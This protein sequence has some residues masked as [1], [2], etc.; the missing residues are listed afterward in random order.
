MAGGCFHC[1]F[2]TRHVHAHHASNSFKRTSDHGCTGVSTGCTCASRLK[3]VQ[4]ALSRI[5]HSE[6]QTRVDRHYGF[7]F[8][9]T[10][11][12]NSHTNFFWRVEFVQ[13]EPNCGC[14]SAETPCREV[15]RLTFFQAR[16]G[17]RLQAVEKHRASRWFNPRNPI[18]RFLRS[19]R[20]IVLHRCSSSLL[21]R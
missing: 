17:E 21:G 15:S 13:A 19:E 16:C 8:V 12:V 6:A 20:V 5:G 14:S 9:Q 4:A 18:N 11:E 3:F 1:F 2:V 7:T 10:T